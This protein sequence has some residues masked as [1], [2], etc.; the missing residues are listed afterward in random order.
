MRV[1]LLA[2]GGPGVGLGHLGRSTALAQALRAAG[3]RPV[4]VG[5]PPSCRAWLAAKG[6]RTETLG[7]GK[8][9]LLVAD[10]Y[11]L[12][13]ADLKRLR[14]QARILAVFDDFGTDAADA[15]PCDQVID[16]RN[17]RYLPLRRE[18]WRTRRTR[19]TP[20]RVRRVLVT[21]GGLDA[22]GRA[23]VLARAAAAALPRARVELVVSPLGRVPAGLR[24][25]TF[26]RNPASLRPLLERADLLVSGGGQTLYEA[27]FAGTPALAFE[28]GKDQR[29][30]LDVLSKAG[31]CLRLGRLDAAAPARL[32]RA[33]Q[34]LDAAPARRARMSAAGRRF[35]DGLGAKRLARLLLRKAGA[36]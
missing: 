6:F 8:Y 14:R 26:K 31:A 35:V 24:G 12:S 2:D 17:P 7:R 11:R 32:K 5:A 15:A 21:L 16:G 4:F 22:G 3:E 13:P 36:R 10:S 20:R 28:L 9:D 30:N 34:A 27:A 19:R 1:A 18:Y 33:L 25:V 29:G 23:T